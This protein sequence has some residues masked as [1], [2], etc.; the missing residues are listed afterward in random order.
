MTIQAPAKVNLALRILARRAD[1][2][3]EIETLM[4]PIS[5]ADEIDI[6]L[7]PGSGIEVTCDDPEIPCGPENLVWRAA[8]AFQKKTGRMFSAKIAIRKKIPHGAGLGGGSSDAAA[9]IKA[10]DRLLETKLPVTD[11]EEIAGTLGSDVPFFIRCK[12][13]LCR[14]RGEQIT[15]ADGV[16]PANLLLLKPPFPVSTAW[17]YQAWKPSMPSTRQF[18]GKIE[19]VNDLEFPVFHKYLLFPV[20]KDWLLEQEEVA[21]AMMTGSGS[22]LFAVLRKDGGSLAQRAKEKFGKT[23]WTAEVAI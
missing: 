13:A 9:V 5:L 10:L 16:P 3:H 4:A 19:L 1:G 17:A 7:S 15:P 12:P 11:L 21:A 6:E 23:L 22:T 2:Y 14:G 8:E 18:L 20:I